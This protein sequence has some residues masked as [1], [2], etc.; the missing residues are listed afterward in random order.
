MEA[1]IWNG[2]DIHDAFCLE[3]DAIMEFEGYE[4][5][6][7]LGKIIDSETKKYLEMVFIDFKCS[8]CSKRTSIM[9]Q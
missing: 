9:S 6:N 8:N 2:V 3:C 1:S 7:E 5:G 4:K